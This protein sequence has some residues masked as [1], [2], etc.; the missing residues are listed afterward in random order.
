MNTFKRKSLYTALAGL[1][2]L[3]ATGAA[4]AVNVNPDGLGQVLVY[5]YYT[6]RATA[7]GNAYASLL[8]VV[9]STSSA[10]AVKVRFL[11][12]KNSREVLDFNLFLSA[13]D[14]WTAAILPSTSGGAKVATNDKSCTLPTLPAGGVDFVNYAYSG[15]GAPNDDNGGGAL[16][17][18]REGY[19]EIIEMGHLFDG[20]T[21]ATQVTHVN[22]VPPGCASI[23]DTQAASDTSYANGGLFGG[24]TLINVAAGT[25]YTEDAVALDNFYFPGDGQYRNAGDIRPQLSDAD[26]FSTVFGANGSVVQ[27]DWTG[28]PN[29]ADAVSAVLMHNN[30]MNEFVL[31]VTTQSG[32]DWVVTMPTKRFYVAVGTGNA[33]RLFQRN[34]NGTAGSCDDVSLDLYDREEF[35]RA[36][37]FSPAPPGSVN[38]ICWEANVIT[39]NGTNVLGSANTSNIPTSFANGW[40]RMGFFPGSQGISHVLRSPAGGTTTTFAGGGTSGTDVTYYGLPVVGFAVQSFLNGTIVVG[41]ASVLSNYGGNFVHKYT[42]LVQ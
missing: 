37:G 42:T 40:M 24:M 34:F 8:S 4:Q 26:P 20:S 31:D 25:D 15:G 13:Y 6:T 28:S 38:R 36:G 12:G 33:T 21:T 14:V 23:T 22:G 32:T 35:K 9:N 27:T 2:A 7:A 39:F 18:T 1:S 29:S 3:G 30:V 17:R 5:P 41:G 16:D 19:V 10:K 11:E